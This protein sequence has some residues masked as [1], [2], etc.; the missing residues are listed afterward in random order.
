MIKIEGDKSALYQWDLNQR[1]VLIDV[2]KDVQVHFSH[3]GFTEEEN[4]ECPVLLSYEEEG[5]VYANI[6]NIFLQKSGI[7]TVYVYV[8]ENNK[9]YT[10]HHAEIIVLYRPKPADY[11]YTDTEV[12]TWESLDKRVKALENGGASSDDIEKVVKEYLEE[13]PVEVDIP[14]TLPNPHRLTFTG[15]VTA[16]YDGSEAVEVKIP[17]GSGGSGIVSYTNPSE[18][19]L[20]NGAQYIF[21]ASGP[22]YFYIKIGSIEDTVYLESAYD[23]LWYLWVQTGNDRGSLIST[24]GKRLVKSWSADTPTVINVSSSAPTHVVIKIG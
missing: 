12:L 24:S 14:D 10:E 3:E 23:C 19:P 7:I 22:A 18:V 16:E 4:N 8:Q 6:P 5:I 9:A 13:N 15:A 20:T 21:Y 11:V 2:K 17:E 1:V